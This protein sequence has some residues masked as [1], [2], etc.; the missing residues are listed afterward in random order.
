[1]VI[2][3]TLLRQAQSAASRTDQ[4]F[5]DSVFFQAFRDQKD[6]SQLRQVM[7]EIAEQNR[8]R[9]SELKFPD[10][11]RAL[12]TK[13]FDSI[14]Q[15]I[16]ESP[17][18]FFDVTSY[19]FRRQLRILCFG[20]VPVGP[21]HLEVDGVPRNLL[22]RGGFHQSYRFLRLLTKIRRFRARPFFVLHLGIH[23]PKTFLLEY[24]AREQKKMFHRLAGCLRMNPEILGVSAS[25]WWYD[26]SMKD[27]S[28]Y[29]CYL[30]E[31]WESKGAEF[32][33]YETSA[34]TDRLATEGSVAR[35]KL[36]EEGKYLP[37]NYLVVWTRDSLLRWA[38]LA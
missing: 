30:R 5:T 20:R 2:P 4:H 25:S 36:F 31:G 34:Q 32:F 19:R 33:D 13:S 16:R 35:T 15:E 17:E 37:R 1:M 3:Q 21:E 28:D 11:V 23:S 24:S 6:S 22:L 8:P 38:D 9:I 26:P 14:G 7:T 10:E 27:H 18:E 12:V 29:L